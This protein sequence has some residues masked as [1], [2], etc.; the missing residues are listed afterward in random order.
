MTQNIYDTQTFFEK[1][2]QLPRSVE[3]LAGAPERPAL[4]AAARWSNLPC[5]RSCS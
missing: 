5:C 3:G 4:A 2:N 1:Y